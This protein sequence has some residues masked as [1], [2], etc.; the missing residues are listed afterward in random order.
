MTGVVGKKPIHLLREEDAKK[1]AHIRDLAWLSLSVD[2]GE[3]EVFTPAQNL[4]WYCLSKEDRSDFSGEEELFSRS[5]TVNP[6]RHRTG[7]SQALY[8]RWM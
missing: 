6:P 5:T 3:G 4:T 1:V 7:D 2:E 8:L